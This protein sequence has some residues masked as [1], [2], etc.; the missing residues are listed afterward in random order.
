[1]HGPDQACLVQHGTG[2]VGGG[3]VTDVLVH[4]EKLATPAGLDRTFGSD[5]RVSTPVGGG[6]REAGVIQP[7]GGLVTAGWGATPRPGAPPPGAAPRRSRP[8]P[9]RARSTSAAGRTGP[10]PPPSAAPTTRRPTRRRSP[11]AGSSS[12]AARTRR[13]C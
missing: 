10:P 12:S 4:C 13:A 8:T 2:T 5:G 7:S 1:P 9:R 6:H 11:T 3:D